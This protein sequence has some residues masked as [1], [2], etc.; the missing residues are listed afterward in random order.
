MNSELSVEFEVKAWRHQ[1]VCCH[2]FHLQE[3]VCKLLHADNL[4]L[5]SETVNGFRKEFL[6]WKV[7]VRKGLRVNHDK[8]NN[9]QWWHQK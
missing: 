7:L 4:I 6:K 2:L 8:T 5:M 9:A 1:N 3:R